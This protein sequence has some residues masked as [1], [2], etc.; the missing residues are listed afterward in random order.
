MEDTWILEIL[1]I[2]IRT[3]AERVALRQAYR[4]LR[5]LGFEP[6]GIRPGSAAARFH[7][8]WP[9]RVVRGSIF[10]TM[11]RWGRTGIPYWT[12]MAIIVMASEM[13]EMLFKIAVINLDA[14]VDR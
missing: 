10:A 12:K 8:R 5:G 14:A 9:E 3:Y 2:V 11:T 4:L 13:A 7:R 6:Y 1:L